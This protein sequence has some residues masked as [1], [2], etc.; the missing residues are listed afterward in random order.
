[1]MTKVT[2]IDEKSAVVALAVTSV[3]NVTAVGG[4]INELTVKQL[5]CDQE[6]FK[7]LCKVFFIVEEIRNCSRTGKRSV[8]SGEVPRPALNQV[9]FVNCKTP[10]RPTVHTTE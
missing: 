8:H 6:R 9:H 2:P 7:Y 10:P 5:K 1:M 4:V 3:D